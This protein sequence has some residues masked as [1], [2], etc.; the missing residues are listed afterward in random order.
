MLVDLRLEAQDTS[1]GSIESTRLASE[2]L[3]TRHDSITC[4]SGGINSADDLDLSLPSSKPPPDSHCHAQ[5]DEAKYRDREI[6]EEDFCVSL[7]SSCAYFFGT[8]STLGREWS[9]SSSIFIKCF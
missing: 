9:N 2:E 7:V 8:K 3:L 5:N 1:S 4:Q 6:L